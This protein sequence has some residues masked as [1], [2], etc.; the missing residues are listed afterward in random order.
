MV[1]F[2][3]K[4]RVLMS[5]VAAAALVATA[6]GPAQ[7]HQASGP[8]HAGGILVYPYIGADL[9]VKSLD[10]AL[11]QD[12][13][14]LQVVNL[15]Y[16]ALLRLDQ[17]NNVVP[18]LAAAMPTV[19]NGGKTY[20]YKIRPDA[21][22]SDGTPVTAQDFVY[23]WTRALSKKEQSPLAMSYMGTIVGAA[24]LNAGKTSTLAGAKAIDAHTVSLT[25]TTPGTYLLAEQTYTTYDVVEQSVAAGEDLVGAGSQSKNV[26]TGPF[27]FSKPWRYKQEM[28]LA[29]NPHWYRASNIKISE[30][31]VPMISNNDVIYREYQAGQVPMTVVTPEHLQADRSKPDF[32]Q[33]P[34]LFID[35]ISL[36]Q[37]KDS[38]CKPVSCAPIN[39]I[40]YR[41]AMMYAIDRTTVNSKILHGAQ[42]NLCGIVPNGIAGYSANLCNLT[43]YNPAKARAELALAK[44]DFGGTLPNDGKQ[45]LIYQTSG[46]AIV[47]EYTEIQSEWAAVG[48]NIQIKGEPFNEWVNLVTAPT[49]A[50][51]LENA[52][53]DDYPDAQDFTHNLLSI[54][55]AYNVANYHDPA[56]EALIAKADVTPNGPDRTNLYI[57]AQQR[58]M[59]SVAFI[60]IGQELLSWRWKSNIQGLVMG[61]G[62]NYPIA[63]GNDWTNVSV[64]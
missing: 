40:H 31:D 46:Q 2:I 28:Y 25:F 57:Q 64:S 32:H 60:S 51:V 43:P 18:D 16:T 38:A 11:L 20:T 58:A 35:Y 10:P 63:A 14:S 17:Y 30:I 36:N 39:D 59:N 6:I 48:I 53:A 7:A 41:L 13:Q 37:S 29:P 19:S 5:A 54:Y 22:F 61:S 49:T 24:A 52:W 47:N 21:K 23:S 33:V 8:A 12:T 56:F 55:G 27:M 15:V 1:G 44:K 34:G 3:S 62:F 50:S 42:V 4:H 26:G 45:T 9:W